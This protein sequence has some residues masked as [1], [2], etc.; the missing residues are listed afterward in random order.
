MLNTHTTSYTFLAG[1][2]SPPLPQRRKVPIVIDVAEPRTPTI[3]DPRNLVNWL[4]QSREISR[5]PDSPTHSELVELGMQEEAR[6]QAEE[7][8]ARIQAVIA[9]ARAIHSSATPRR[10]PATHE[11][12]DES[13]TDTEIL[14]HLNLQNVDGERGFSS[15][16]SVQF[17][18]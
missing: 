18:R 16:G 14:Q 5:R 11:E 6:I 4:S 9:H 13:N 2:V 3:D 1:A 15:P 17:N 10:S 8:E 7:E 12:M